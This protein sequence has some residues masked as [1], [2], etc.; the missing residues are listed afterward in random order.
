MKTIGKWL[1]A[2]SLLAVVALV[3][4][5]DPKKTE[6]KT[7]SE[8]AHAEHGDHGDAGQHGESKTSAKTEPAKTEPMKTEPAKTVPMPSEN[9]TDLKPESG[10][11]GSEE[12][13]GG[14]EI[15]KE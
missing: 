12:K 2:M 1:T 8:P 15:P 3:G 5:G 7:S 6:T 11:T 10:E 14:L 4:C 9:G 13:P